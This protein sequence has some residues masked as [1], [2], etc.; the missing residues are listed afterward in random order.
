M[1]ELEIVLGVEWSSDL[2]MELELELEFELSSWQM[3]EL[4]IVLSDDW[5][6]E[7]FTQL[8]VMVDGV[9]CGARGRKDFAS[10]SND[11]AGA[12]SETAACV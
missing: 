12:R 10:G 3:A 4:E 11:G 5:S 8:L 2:L 1:T 6:S 9:L 7:L